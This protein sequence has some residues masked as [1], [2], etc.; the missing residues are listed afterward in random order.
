MT[1]KCRFCKG[2][3][4]EP[5]FTECVWCDSSGVDGGIQPG[6]LKKALAPRFNKGDTD[7]VGDCDK[8]EAGIHVGAWLQRIAVYGDSPADAEALRDETLNALVSNA[9]LREELCARAGT[10]G[11]LTGERDA[12]QAL[13][14][15]ADER[16]DVQASAL[17]RIHDRCEAFIEDERDMPI[18]SVEV[19]RDIAARAA[20]TPAEAAK[21]ARCDR[22]T[23]E[24]CDDAGCGFLGAGNGAPELVEEE[25]YYPHDHKDTKS[26]CK[27]CNAPWG[28]AYNCVAS[29]TTGKARDV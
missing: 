23:V 4:S 2:A 27:K 5:G 28:V 6:A 19:I 22:S 16:A 17:A 3:G 24:Q 13:L 25:P 8:F 21:C 26:P 18:I 20:L 10:I 12:L 15:A 14:T 29:G 11:R 9:A 7:P 1:T